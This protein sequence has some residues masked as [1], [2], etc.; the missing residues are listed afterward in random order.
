VQATSDATIRALSERLRQADDELARL[1]HQVA[2]QQQ[3]PPPVP[4]GMP[5]QGRRQG[6]P[7]PP[8]PQQSR[9]SGPPPPPGDRRNDGHNPHGWA[10]P[11]GQQWSPPGQPLPPPGARPPQAQPQPHPQPQPQ[12][13][14]PKQPK[15]RGAGAKLFD[16]VMVL[17]VLVVLYVATARHPNL[18]RAGTDLRRMTHRSIVAAAVTATA[19]V[20]S[21][22][23]ASI[24]RRPVGRGLWIHLLVLGGLFLAWAY[25]DPTG[26][27]R[28][29]IRWVNINV[30]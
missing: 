25:F 30:P 4:R 2:H 11:R 9:P 3:P 10:P 21:L 7:P 6:P 15:K 8:Q 22:F 12:P 17:V 26:T 28:Q 5:D 14:P 20:L 16:A 13:Q 29:A 19:F 23:T 24:G 27:A 1:R 18:V